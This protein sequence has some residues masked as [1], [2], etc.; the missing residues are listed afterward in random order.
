MGKRDDI[1]KIWQE[2]F[3]DSREYVAMYFDRVYRDDE[4]MLL[5]DPQGAPVS[6]LLLQRYEMTMHGRAVPV[7]YIAGAATRRQYRGRGYMSE[8]MTGAL[9]ESA[10]RGDMLC[11][12]IPASEALFI[13]YRRYGFSTVFYAKEQRYTALHPFPVKGEYEPAIDAASDHLWE[14]FDRLQHMRPCYVVHDRRQFENILADIAADRGD[15]VALT[16]AGSDEI[17]AM[18]WGVIRGD[19]L[20]VTDL[21][22]ETEDARTGALRRLREL[23]PGVPF[24]VYGRPGDSNGGRL[25]PRGMARVVNARLLLDT[26]AS[27]DPKLECRVRVTDHILPELNSHSYL[28]AGGVCE[29]DDSIDPRRLDFDVTIEVLADIAFS[30]AR[31]GQVLRFPSER[32][33]ISLMLD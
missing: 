14:A 2:S 17:V 19:L 26:V 20:L 9:R 1:M 25:M 6:S 16:A 12:L 13:F 10:A 24:L 23:H 7:S 5:T 31:M 18:A 8:L 3:K 22:G 30:S 4:A 29:V 32:P 21:M 28:M 33:M 11:T 15:F 27:A